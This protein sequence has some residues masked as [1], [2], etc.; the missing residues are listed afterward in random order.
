[1]KIIISASSTRNVQL[2]GVTAGL[3]YEI[4]IVSLRNYM[5]NH[6]GNSFSQDARQN[7]KS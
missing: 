6:K 2:Q 4:N 7:T 5:H 3:V 1:M